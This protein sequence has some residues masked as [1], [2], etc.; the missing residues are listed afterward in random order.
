MDICDL[1]RFCDYICCEC[2]VDT[3]EILVTL[4]EGI[5]EFF[6]TCVPLFSISALN[7]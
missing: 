1:D 5:N 7:A 6:G 3:Q 4:V 2:I